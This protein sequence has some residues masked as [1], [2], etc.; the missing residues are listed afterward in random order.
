MIRRPPR[1]TLSSSSAAS[2]VY[3]RQILGSRRWYLGER[4]AEL[5]CQTGEWQG[6]CR[7]RMHTVAGETRLKFLI[8]GKWDSRRICHGDGRLPVEHGRLP[9]T[10]EVGDSVTGNCPGDESAVV[11][12]VEAKPRASLPRG[13]VLHVCGHVKRFVVIDAE[14]PRGPRG[15]GSGSRDLRSEEAGSDAGHDY[16]RGEAV[17]H[18]HAGAQR[19]SGNLRVM[20]LDR[21]ED[22]RI[23]QYAEIVGAVRVLPDVFAVDH[24]ELSYGLLQTGM[25][26]I[27][28][29][30][31]QGRRRAR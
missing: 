17:I 8:G 4:R 26:F 12:P 5:R 6:H 16:Q 22:R 3:K 28:K 2:D 20:P 31:R 10:V 23:A 14:N 19:K 30:G 27:A 1:S 24:Q 29:A 21:E 13:L 7:S 25:E 18:R 11:A 15:S 9:A